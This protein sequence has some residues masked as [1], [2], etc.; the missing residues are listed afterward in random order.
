MNFSLPV[1]LAK[2]GTS[3]ALSDYT[4]MTGYEQWSSMLMS[5]APL[6]RKVQ[7]DNKTY[8]MVIFSSSTML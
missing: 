8:N 1:T 2:F 3:T 7:K 6:Y 5:R 4:I